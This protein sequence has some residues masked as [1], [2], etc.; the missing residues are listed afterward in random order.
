MYIDPAI[1]VVADKLVEQAW[2]IE[3]LKQALLSVRLNI[4]K[5][6][7]HE[8]ERELICCDEY[9]TWDKNSGPSYKIKH[10]IC[11]WGSYA[12]AIALKVGTKE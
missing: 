10:Q 7:A 11:W 12:R 3:A 4:A 8:I 9:E 5:E 2:E 6:I 1:Q